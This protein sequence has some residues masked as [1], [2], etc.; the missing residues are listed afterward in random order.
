MIFAR[1]F[2]VL[3]QIGLGPW[4][5]STK[6]VLDI[7]TPWLGPS[8]SQVLLRISPPGQGNFQKIITI[9]IFLPL[10]MAPYPTPDEIEEMMAL[11]GVPSLFHTFLAD[12]LDVTVVGKEFHIGGHYNSIEAFHEGIYA[13]VAAALK[14]E[15]IRV[16]VIRV[17]GGGTSAW[18]C[19]ESKCTAMSKYGESL[20]LDLMPDNARD[21]LH[22][23]TP[24]RRTR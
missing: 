17:I 20:S 8:V 11:R 19:V 15:T 22:L 7:R 4:P 9:D 6:Y 10:I 1:G 2:P 3:I 14:E 13:R 12:H 21:P 24:G 16:E 5:H 18:A 23:P